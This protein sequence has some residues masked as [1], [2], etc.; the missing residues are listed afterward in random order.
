MWQPERRPLTRVVMIAALLACGALLRASPQSDRSV[1]DSKWSVGRTPD[2]QPDLQG[3]WTNYDQTPFERLTAEEQVSRGPAVSTADWLVQDSPTSP[4]R[5]SMVVDPPDGRVPLKPE[6]IAQRDKFLVLDAGSPEGY[7]PWERCITR[8]VPGSMW[9]GAYNNGH[10]IVQ[11]PGYVV[12]HSEMIHEAR[13]IPLDGRPYPSVAVRSWD[14]DSRGRWEGD[15][16]VIT[17]TNFSGN[18]WVATNAASG[19][20]RGIALSQAARVVERLTRVD[21]TT[22]RYEATIE[23]PSAYTK[24][25]TVAFPLNRDERYRIFEYAC[26]EG[27]HALANMLRPRAN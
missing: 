15:T 23:D 19:R 12:L 13:V 22:I 8:G 24:A 25:W 6:A 10:Q 27:N 16:L 21:E 14:G 17:T 2:G 26:H 5:P 20:V 18:G 9:P 4:R 3:T 1:A 11:T 7:G